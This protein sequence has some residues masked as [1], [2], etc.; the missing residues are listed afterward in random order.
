MCRA[1]PL[2]PGPVDY[3]DS[4]LQAVSAYQEGLDGIFLV[5]YVRLELGVLQSS[6]GHGNYHTTA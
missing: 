1:T 4:G 2:P 3:T 5:L 6:Q